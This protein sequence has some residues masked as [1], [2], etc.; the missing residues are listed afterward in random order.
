[1][2]IELSSSKSSNSDRILS[3]PNKHPINITNI[4][5]WL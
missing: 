1:M 5:L 3:K 2:I 4:L